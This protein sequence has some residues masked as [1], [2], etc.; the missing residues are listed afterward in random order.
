MVNPRDQ[1]QPSMIMASRQVLLELAYLL[2]EERDKIVFVGGTACT[3]LFPQDIDPHEG[4]IDIDVALNPAVLVEYDN[5][6]L[7][8]KI[9]AP[10]FSAML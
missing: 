8:E 9:S 4:T 5:E 3:L 2:E 6:T 1:Y 10:I 7:E